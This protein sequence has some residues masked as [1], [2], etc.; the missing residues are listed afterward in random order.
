[1]RR[2]ARTFAD[3]ART[4]GRTVVAYQYS[5]LG[6]P[7]DPEIVRTLH[8]AQVPLLLGISNAMGA[9]RHLPIRREYWTR[10]AP[11]DVPDRAANGSGPGTG[12]DPARLDFL[13]I[14]DALIASGVP[15]LETSHAHS[16]DDAVA[17]QRRLGRA[18]AVKAESPG[19]LHKSDLGC[20][21]LGCATERDV[22]EAYREVAQNAR[23][24]GFE[25][26]VLIQPMIEGVAEAYAGII[27]DPLFGPAICFGI[28]GVYIEIMKDTITEMAPLSHDDALGM[29]RRIK[30][31]AILEGARGRERADVEALAKLL[32]G[33][34][35]FAIENS[36]RFRALDLN[37]II[38]GSSGAIAVDIAIEPIRR[39]A[40]D[41]VAN[42]AE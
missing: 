41:A 16:E 18:V 8:C 11:E 14:R 38:V 29:I 39:D 42:A 36:G 34:G 3:A 17:L 20:V 21:G 2:F 32:V 37:P 33:L 28:G 27:D 10:V 35:R 12:G 6:G 23:N 40:P 22:R 24:A 25:A 9:L 4:S 26:A 30:A 13:G 15:V 7:L 19:L 1:M 31:S 5:P